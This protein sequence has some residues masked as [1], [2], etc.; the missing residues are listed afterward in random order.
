M[1][2]PPKST[3]SIPQGVHL[4]LMVDCKEMVGDTIFVG[5]LPSWEFWAAIPVKHLLIDV[6]RKKR[7]WNHNWL[8]WAGNHNQNHSQSSCKTQ[9]ETFVG[10]GLRKWLYNYT[11][12]VHSVPLRFV[13]FHPNHPKP[14]FQDFAPINTFS[15]KCTPKNNCTNFQTT[16]QVGHSKQYLTATCRT[17]NVTGF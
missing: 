10:G 3:N 13:V 6:G 11:R 9:L 17:Y 8:E 5:N 16:G 7:W 14:E 2:R 4:L 12:N 1:K 15:P